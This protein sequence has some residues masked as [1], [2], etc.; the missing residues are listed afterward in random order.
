MP[1]LSNPFRGGPRLE[2][3]WKAEIDDH[4][5]SLAWSPSG[6]TLAAASVSGPITLFEPESYCSKQKLLFGTEIGPSGSPP[7]VVYQNEVLNSTCNSPENFRK[8]LRVPL[9]P[10]R[11]RC[12]SS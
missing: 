8:A 1:G 6:K 4:V 5:I 9:S 2:R 11:S 3:R 7:T 12:W 10:P